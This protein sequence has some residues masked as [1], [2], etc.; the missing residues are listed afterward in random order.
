VGVVLGAATVAAATAEILARGD[1]STV[2]RGLAYLAQERHCLTHV[3]FG[4]E[5]GFPLQDTTMPQPP[6]PA[7]LALQANHAMAI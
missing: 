4:Q 3:A 1:Q 5:A 2:R 6:A 7:H